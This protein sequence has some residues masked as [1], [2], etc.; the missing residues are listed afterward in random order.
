M[1]EWSSFL[2][3]LSSV[4]IELSEFDESIVWFRDKKR[5]FPTVKLLYE[6]LL[7][8]SI[9]LASKWQ[10][11]RIWKVILPLKIKYFLW[12]AI[13]NKLLTQGNYQKRGGIL[14]NCCIHC[15]ANLEIVDHVG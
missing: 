9:D 3:Y 6:A 2:K 5:G 14:V 11:K 13:E 12:I 15:G 10:Y 8:E 4:G 7:E 1:D